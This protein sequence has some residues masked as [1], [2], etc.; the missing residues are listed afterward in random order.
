MNIGD[1]VKIKLL[2]EIKSRK[3]E[4]LGSRR[5]AFYADDLLFDPSMKQYCGDTVSISRVKEKPSGYIYKVYENL[6]WWHE[7]W[8]VADFLSDDDFEI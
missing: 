2:E 3:D 1:R 5:I 6:W 7:R 8:L 4:L